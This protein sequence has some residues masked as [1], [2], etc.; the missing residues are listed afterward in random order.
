MLTG[1][2]EAAAAQGHQDLESAA[3]SVRWLREYLQIDTTNPPGNELAGVRYLATILESA[4]IESRILTSP[5]GRASLYAR[6]PATAESRGTLVLMHH[7]DV[8]P[9]L[10]GWQ[11]EP[12]SGR[13]LNDKIWGRGALDVKGLGIAQLVATLAL[14]R[15]GAE[16]QRDVV[17]LAVADEE[18]GGGQG[19]GWLVEAH[20]ELFEGVDAV[21]N[22]GGSNRV[23]NDRVIWWGIEVTQKRPLWL[24]VTA[25]GRGGHASG[26]HPA[27]ATHRLIK[28]LSRLIERSSRPRANAAAR[29]YL[30]A[31]AELE[32]GQDSELMRR[33][34]RGGD[35]SEVPMPPGLSIYF[36]DSLQVT[37]IDNGE[38]PNV[39]S[40]VARAS[41]D[42]R[43]LPDTDSDAF[44]A[45]IKE[46]LGQDLD[47]QVLLDAPPAAASPTDHPVFELLT[48][49]LS[50]R[51]PVVPSFL[52]GTTDS[53]YFRQRG[54]PAYGFSPFAIN[55]EDLRGIHARDESIPVDAFLRG[56]ETLRRFLELYVER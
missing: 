10:D 2:S 25:R 38:G 30:G 46:L 32:G 55:P 21:L 49:A 48:Q 52:T 50:V 42:V 26:F 33:L 31:L 27:S 37:A 1:A 34:D 23:L 17:L 11:V 9:A 20:P 43:L 51:A 7:I 14:E 54:I 8:V 22:E 53:R 39:V 3:Q 12:F 44:L 6:L 47:V 19:T 29:T 36:I 56:I 24:E 16:R 28:G 41:V 18:V 15:S 13:P 45:E 5:Q 35:L 4:G 40:P